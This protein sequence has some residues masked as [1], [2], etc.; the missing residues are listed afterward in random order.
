MEALMLSVSDVIEE[1]V[2]ELQ[3]LREAVAM[4]IEQL[5]EQDQFIVNAVNSEFL[6]Y[7]QLGKRLGVS[8]PHAW[9]LKNN[10]YAKLQQLLTMHPLIRKKVR[11]V[12]TW[13]QSAS[14]W[15]MHIASFA[16]EEQEILPEKLQRLIQSARVCLFDQDDIPVSLLWT[17]MG[18]EAIQELR[19]HNAWDSGKMCT[20]LA[21]KQHDYGH[22]NITAF[23][24]KGVLVR[25]SDKV[26][27][28]INL[29][30]KKFKAQN[31]SLLDTLRDIVGYCVIALMLNDET[32]YLELG[33]NY[34]N[35]S[36]SDW[37]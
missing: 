6:S 18:I 10:A 2:E 12:N 24:L 27:R 11:V 20:L 36:A 22:G 5:D 25:L 30:S 8:K 14:Q 17:E 13:E 4:C 21:S 23:G 9:R 7:E 32:F 16:T 26:E 3:P 31:E 1:S 33:E 37:I 19:M 35:E 29:K 15:V 28:L 34:A